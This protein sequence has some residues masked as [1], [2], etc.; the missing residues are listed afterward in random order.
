M[1]LSDAAHASPAAGG[2]ARPDLSRIPVTVHALDPVS[3]AG[4][5]SQLREHPVLDVTE[6]P[7]PGSGAVAVLVV[8]TL[9]EGAY[10]RLRKVVRGEGAR[11]VL[12]VG[13]LREHELL[14]VVECGVGAVVWRHEATAGRLLQAVLAASRGDGHLPGDLLSRLMDQAG[15]LHRGAAGRPDAVPAGL[16]S[17][18]ADVLRLLAEGMETREVAAELAYSERTV[19]T[20]L[21]GLTM[22]L[23]LR[24]RTHAV[25]HALREGLI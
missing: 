1:H 24:N 6:V 5:R 13:T 20:V 7:P 8:E 19:K 22:R 18:E 10:A 2:T 23:H 25:A 15:T 3:R 9:D 11:S 17:R 21:Q 12:V 16:T 14:D 4:L